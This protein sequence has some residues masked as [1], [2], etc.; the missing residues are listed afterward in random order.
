MEPKVLGKQRSNLYEVAEPS[1]DTFFVRIPRSFPGRNSAILGQ[2]RN[3]KKKSYNTELD[4]VTGQ[5]L[6]LA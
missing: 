3:M 4:N 1:G 2:Q 6:I 5:P